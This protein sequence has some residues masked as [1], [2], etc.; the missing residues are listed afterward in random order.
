MSP[1]S[2]ASALL[3]V[4]AGI[5]ALA[6]GCGGGD[7][8]GGKARADY[9]KSADS[10]CREA[11]QV[12]QAMGQAMQQMLSQGNTA[13]VGE[14]IAQYQPAY[15]QQLDRLARLKSPAGDEARTKAIVTAMNLR[16]DDIAVQ[17]RAMK[18]ND[19][20]LMAEV[21]AVADGHKAKAQQLSEK[22][23]LKI[24]GT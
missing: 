19:K 3:C 17:A 9:I 13:G 16:A 2:R 1:R 14:V 15:R 18:N 10:I 4:L 8:S 24:C 23:G 21:Q 6:A 11:G 20:A 22:Y 7:D 12:G 5:S